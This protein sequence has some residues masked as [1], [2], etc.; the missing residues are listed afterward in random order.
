[1]FIIFSL[2]NQLFNKNIKPGYE[3]IA[4]GISGDEDSK[5]STSSSINLGKPIF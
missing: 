5:D 1:M 2:E 3:K 4:P